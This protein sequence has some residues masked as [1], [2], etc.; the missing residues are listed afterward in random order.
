MKSQASMFD[1]IFAMLILLIFSIMLLFA[2]K[3]YGSIC[4]GLNSTGI[5]ILSCTGSNPA[6]YTG[7]ALG[8]L[9]D[10]TIMVFVSLIVGAIVGGYFVQKHPIFAIGDIFMLFLVLLLSQIFTNVFANMVALNTF[11]SIANQN[12]PSIVLIFQ[13][14]GVIALV[15]GVALIV[16]QYGKPPKV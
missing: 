1:L 16:I 15:S 8:I 11:I 2:F 12:L 14:L 9:S 10:T 5:P 13:G 6:T 3:L 7:T 4:T